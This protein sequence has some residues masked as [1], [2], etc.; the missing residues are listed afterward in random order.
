MDL[1]NKFWPGARA[2]GIG[3]GYNPD[4]FFQVT[5][6]APAPPGPFPVCN[7]LGFCFA[8]LRS[9]WPKLCRPPPPEDLGLGL[10]GF[11]GSPFWFGDHCNPGLQILPFS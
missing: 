1:R 3:P 2:R 11:G 8:I 7:F 10:K 4:G 9:F 6:G 5:A